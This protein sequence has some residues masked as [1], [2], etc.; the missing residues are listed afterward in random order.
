MDINF[1]LYKVFYSVAKNKSMSKA[2]EELGVTQPAVTASIKRL[3]GQ[4]GGALFIRSNKVLELTA[5]GDMLFNKV[6]NAMAIFNEAE[7]MFSDFLN[8]QTGEIRIGISSVLTKI[9]LIDTIKKFN[10]EYPNIKIVIKN[11]LT[12][13]L[14]NDLNK[15]KRDFVIFNEGFE[16]VVNVDIQKITE[17]KYV[18]AANEVVDVNNMTLIVQDKNSFTRKFMDN[19]MQEHGINFKEGISVVSQ[20]LA[21]EMASNGLGVCFA[22]EK[23]I[24]KK[25]PELKVVSGLPVCYN[26]IFI[27]INKFSTSTIAAK[28]IISMLKKNIKEDLC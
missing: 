5:E 15:G 18:F 13:E 12:S 2:A 3:E 20:D 6:G 23:L 8:L 9:L 24:D 28:R 26:D 21:C 27:A 11:G 17:L 7:T 22:F 14:L 16:N 4:L 10:Q 19:Y 1:E 25:Y